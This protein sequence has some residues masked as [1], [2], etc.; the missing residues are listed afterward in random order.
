[1]CQRPPLWASCLMGVWGGFTGGVNLETGRDKSKARVKAFIGS[2]SIAALPRAPSYRTKLK[3]R[4]W[5][6]AHPASPPPAFQELLFLCA[7]IF[8]DALHLC[9]VPWAQR[10][11]SGRTPP[12]FV[13]LEPSFC[14]ETVPGPRAQACFSASPTDCCPSA[15]P[16]AG[17]A[18]PQWFAL[19]LLPARSRSRTKPRTKPPAT[20]AAL[21]A[22]SAEDPHSARYR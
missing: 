12:L 6:G 19:A 14:R 8:L 17:C 13:P 4:A 16:G 10:R 5:N 2:L 7:P 9:R 21:P 15:S 11:T 22:T 3:L 20:A 1:M 18:G